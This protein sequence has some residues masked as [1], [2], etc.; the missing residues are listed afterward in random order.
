INRSAETFAI[1]DDAI[2]VGLDAIASLN[3]ELRATLLADRQQRG[4]Y[5]NLADFRRR[6]NPGPEAI[7]L[8]IRCG[9]L[10]FT[11]QIR[12]ALFLEAELQ[13]KENGT[14]NK[15]HGEAASS[16]L[17]FDDTAPFHELGRNEGWSPADYDPAYRLRDEWELL[18]FVVGPR[19]MSLFRP[20]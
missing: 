8:L 7:G 2:R 14:R 16:L 19:L 15:E 12:P 5:R 11:E 9:A 4:P 20:R 18:G 13:D 1:E 17:P 3:E 6:L 10:D